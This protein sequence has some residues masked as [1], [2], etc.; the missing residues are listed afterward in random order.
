VEFEKHTEIPSSNKMADLM[1]VQGMAEGTI[2][3]ECIKH[4]T[5]VYMLHP[6]FVWGSL[7]AK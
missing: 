5:N 6:Y 4:I 3:N 7:V 1:A 2:A